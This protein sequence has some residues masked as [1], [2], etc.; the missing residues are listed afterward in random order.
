[1]L[2]E[3]VIIYLWH[4]CLVNYVGRE[5]RREGTLEEATVEVV[6]ED[7]VKDALVVGGVERVVAVEG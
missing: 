4:L 2:A 3:A 6:P 7:L 1:M 5:G